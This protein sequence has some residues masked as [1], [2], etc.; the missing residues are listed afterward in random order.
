M[1]NIYD[2]HTAA[3]SRVSAYVIVKDGE[4]V[5][6]IA[7]KFPQD[8]AGR[9][10]AYVH[11]FGS[12]MVRGYAGGYGYDKQSAAVE[13][14]IIKMLPKPKSREELQEYMI[15]DISKFTNC[16]CNIGGNSWDNALRDAGFI[17]LQ[18]V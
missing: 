2:Q 11:Y 8:G 5:A 14:A 1:T 10:Y 17:V 13:D 18:A 16:L 7:F 6:T 4:R 3:F 15:K 12:E 9:L